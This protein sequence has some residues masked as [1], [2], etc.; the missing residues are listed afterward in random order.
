[1]DTTTPRA[2]QPLSCG[3]CDAP[4]QAG[5]AYCL[6]CGARRG[7]LSSRVA[8]TIGALYERGR[9]PVVAEPEPEIEQEPPPPRLNWRTPLGPKL[10]T[11]RAASMAVTAMLGFGVILGSL[12]HVSVEQ[13]AALPGWTLNLP[14]GGSSSAPSG[15]S[16]GAGQGSGGGSGATQVQTITVGG[17]TAPATGGGTGSTGSSGARG[18]GSSTGAGGFNGL[19]AIQHVFLIML[20][21]EGYGETFSTSSTDSYLNKTLPGQGELIPGYYAVAGSP[22]ANEIALLSGQGPTQQTAANCPT[23]NPL[24]ATGSGYQG[25]VLGDGC[26]Y[27]ASTQTLMDQLTAA[28]K[29]WRAYIEGMTGVCSR[30]GLGT[31]DPMPSSTS[32]PYAPW[33]NPAIFF[34]S[35]TGSKDCR[36]DDVPLG[37]LKTDLKTE[38]RTPSFSYIA[39]SPC[40]DG[41]AQPCAAGA[42]A[43]LGPADNFLHTVVAEIKA[44]PA[45]RSGGL[46]LVTADEAPQTGAGADSSSCCSQPTFPNLPPPTASTTPTTTTTTTTPTDTTT[47]ATTTSPTTTDTTPTDTTTTP[48]PTTPPGGGQVGLLLISKWVKPGDVDP[49][50]TFNHFSLL[51]GIEELF[52]LKELGYA[53]GSGLLTW[54][55]SGVFSGKGP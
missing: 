46:I 45:Y 12:G 30:P 37:Q 17:A 28:H 4:M 55:A 27:P 48:A 31:A 49:I 42:P 16:S 38:A 50:D 19:P 43:G 15:D 47:T 24:T 2:N 11:P 52:G 41:S 54:T 9:P 40:D 8:G 5:Q 7:Q 39:P 36:K 3:E 22:L 20:S 29:T 53:K 6:E 26:V 44:S 32:R 10:P 1:M 34:D 23:Y 33:T 51:K 21:Q 14:T 18:S 13:L 35:V 25:Q